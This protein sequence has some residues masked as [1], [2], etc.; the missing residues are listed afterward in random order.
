MSDNIDIHWTEDD[1]LLTRFILGRLSDDERRQLEIHLHI[2]PRCRQTVQAEQELASGIRL[3][4]RENLKGHLRQR[5]A[6]KATH[7]RSILT[8]QRALSAAAVL[9]IVTGIS[10]YNGWFPGLETKRFAVNEE[11]HEKMHSEAADENVPVPQVDITKTAPS[12]EKKGEK[13]TLAKSAQEK[14][15]TD[16]ARKGRPA[17]ATEQFQLQAESGA[18]MMEKISRTQSNGGGVTLD[19]ERANPPGVVFNLPS[20]QGTFWI[21]GSYLNNAG[22]LVKI[23]RDQFHEAGKTIRAEEGAKSIRRKK[24]AENSQKPVLLKSI[25]LF[26]RVVA[27]LPSEEGGLLQKGTSSVPAKIEPLEDHLRMTL[28]LES[29]FPEAELR[30]AG[31]W[32]IS[33]DSVVIELGSVKLGFRMPFTAPGWTPFRDTTSIR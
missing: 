10:I 3:Y 27:D 19:K 9:V 30:N 6:A 14:T 15:M 24:G 31:V 12:T 2:C 21:A 32:G 5:I 25:E 26:Q 13:Q 18:K 16:E 20:R 28:Y 17:G 23:S 8:W 7:S 29:L 1:D 33:P 11:T 4:G 22:T